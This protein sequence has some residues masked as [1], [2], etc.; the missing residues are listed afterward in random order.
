MPGE[1]NDPPLTY[2]NNVPP[3]QGQQ[4]IKSVHVS[5]PSSINLKGNL[6]KNWESLSN[7]GTPTTGLKNTEI[8]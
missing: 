8:K 4:G 2:G 1:E 6:K 5:L 7:C 3:P